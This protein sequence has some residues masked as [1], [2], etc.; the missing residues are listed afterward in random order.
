M[1]ESV[2]EYYQRMRVENNGIEVS[3]DVKALKKIFAYLKRNNIREFNLVF[4]GNVQINAIDY[5]HIHYIHIESYH[6]GL[7]K[8]TVGF[9]LEEVY[10]SFKSV[11]KIVTG[12]FYNDIT[13]EFEWITTEGNKP[14]ERTIYIDENMIPPMP[15]YSNESI[16][17]DSNVIYNTCKAI[18]SIEKESNDIKRI[19]IKNASDDMNI[20]AFNSD[21]SV[22]DVDYTLKVWLN[23]AYEH[24]LNSVYDSKRLEKLLSIPL[25]SEELHFFEGWKNEVL[26]I[27]VP[28][29]LSGATDYGFSLTVMLAP[30]IED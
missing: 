23:S 15:T 20:Y 10:T 5:T 30:R 9:D 4:D 29:V 28:F 17:I 27:D 3:V 11:E 22:L 8:M 7:P 12:F 2:I 21:L 14:F 19:N 18:N 6:V 13:H 25:V 26:S 24:N 1:S 16:S